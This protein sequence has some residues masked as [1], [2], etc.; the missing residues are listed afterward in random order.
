MEKEVYKAIKRPKLN[1][2]L[3]INSISNRFLRIILD[4]LIGAFIY[5]S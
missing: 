2:I 3:K 5:L 1:K 4:R